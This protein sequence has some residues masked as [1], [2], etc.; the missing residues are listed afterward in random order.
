MDGSSEEVEDDIALKE[1][2]DE[3]GE[4][5]ED[6]EMEDDDEIDPAVEMSDSAMVN[7]AAA[8]ADADG[9]LPPLTQALSKVGYCLWCWL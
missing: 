1:L 9:S 5:H 3:D 2:E 6:D 7:E 8:E 4:E